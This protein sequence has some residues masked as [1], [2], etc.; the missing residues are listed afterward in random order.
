MS[1]KKILI[2]DDDIDERRLIRL[3]LKDF[4]FEIIEAS[5]GEEGVMLATAMQP[6]L[7]IFDHRMPKLT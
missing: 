3:L 7:I 4:D 6:D 2:V 1:Q 5:D